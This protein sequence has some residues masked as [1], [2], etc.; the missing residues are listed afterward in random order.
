MILAS[1]EFND[2]FNNLFN[3]VAKTFAQTKFR[4]NQGTAKIN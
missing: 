4:G 1:K 2:T 3:C